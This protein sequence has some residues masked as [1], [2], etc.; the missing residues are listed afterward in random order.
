MSNPLK[1]WG[2]F[3]YEK[4]T[5][6]PTSSSVARRRDSH[7][8]PAEEMGLSWCRR[9]C[10]GNRKTMGQLQGGRSEM[11]RRTFFP[12]LKSQREA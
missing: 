11:E 9:V 7:M 12:M 6:P 1:K 8:I 5:S 2:A 10:S 4:R 3:C